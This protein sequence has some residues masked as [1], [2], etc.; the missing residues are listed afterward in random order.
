MDES[1]TTSLRA[2]ATERGLVG[3][4][5]GSSLVGNDY[6]SDGVPVIRGSNL[7]H[8][9]YVGGDFVYVSE[10]RAN[11]DLARNLAMPDDLIFTQRGTLGQVAMIPTDGQASYVVSQSQMRL[12][13][14]P[15]VAD[16]RFV[17]YACSMPAFLRQVADN[18]IAT[19]VPHINLGILSRLTIELPLLRHQKA[20]AAVLGA[21]DDKIAANLRAEITIDELLAALYRRAIDR[22]EARAVPLFDALDVEFGE[23]FAGASFTESGI[24]RPLIRIRD[25]KTYTSQIWTTESRPKESIVQA[26]DVVVGMDAEF[27]PTIWLGAPG[28]LNQRVC[29]VRCKAAG[30]AFVRETLRIPLAEIENYKSATTVIHLNKADLARSTIVVPAPD[31]LTEFELLAEPLLARRVASAYE[32]QRLMATRDAL[33]PALMSG[34]L[35]VNDAERPIED[36]V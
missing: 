21:L 12:R 17:Y 29:R 6:V 10:V 13:V 11:S 9:R 22:P 3:G 23:P 27:R 32:R 1:R 7:N 30:S 14:N 35:R 19:G 31:A 15:A 16:T 8:G 25:L 24:G 2:L 33:L 20:I 26:G 34:R 36:A 18:A 4:P 28:L 5:F